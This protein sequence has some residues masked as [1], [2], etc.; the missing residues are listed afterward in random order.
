MHPNQA[1]RGV[2]DKRNLDFA[3][4][5]GFGILTISG[6]EGPLA[7]HIPFIVADDGAVVAAHIVRS[8]PIWRALRGGEAKALI[9]VSGPDGYVSPDWYGAVDQVPTWNYVAVN[10]RGTLRL[11]DQAALRAH[12]DDL[13]ARFEIHLAP[14]PV[15][16]SSKMDQE[17][18]ARMMRTIAPIEMR[19]E[20][21]HGTWKLNQNKTEDARL[22]AARAIADSGIGM[23]LKELAALMTKPPRD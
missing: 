3:R 21:V 9:A 1:F 14:K 10:L 13:S 4:E 22:G 23:E 19:I 16:H 11:L 8:N 2:E 5:R 12:L 17:V 20:A 15:W 7:S 18:M 6:A